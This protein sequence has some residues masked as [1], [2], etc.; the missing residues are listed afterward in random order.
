[1]LFM[2]IEHFKDGDPAP[3]YRRLGEQGRLTPAGVEYLGSWVTSDV[4]RCYQVME[5]ANRSL[6]E[7]WMAQW[8]D[9]VRF[10]VVEVMT[11]AAA[12]AAV[13]SRS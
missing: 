4:T 10:E 1:M 6:L 5:C 13:A 8:A 9:L 2:V 3:V 11:S 12:A 7:A